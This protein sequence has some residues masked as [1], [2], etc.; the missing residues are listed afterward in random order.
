MTILYMDDWERLGAFPDYNTT[1]T[2]ALRLATVY[3]KMGIKNHMFHLCL[4]DKELVGVDPFA[5][6]LSLELK[7]RVVTEFKRNFWY[8]IREVIMIPPIGGVEPIKY[9][10]HRA[11]TALHWLYFNNTFNI[12]VIARQRGKTMAVICLMIWLLQSQNNI[13]IASI[14]K[15]DDLRSEIIR[16]FKDV[17]EAQPSYLHF[18]GAKHNDSRNLQEFSVNAFNNI[19]KMAVPSLSPKSAYKVGRGLTTPT[20]WS[21]ES[22]FSPNIG[23]SLGACIASGTYAREQAQL[24]DAPNGIILT[25]TA[26]LIDDRDAGY[27]YDLAMS[28]TPFTEKMYDLDNKEQC[29]RVIRANNR[30]AALRVYAVFNHRQLGVT[31]RQ[32]QEAIVM[33][34]QSKSDAE[35]DFLSIWNRGSSTHPLSVGILNDLNSQEREPDYVN[36]YH[37]TDYIVNWYIPQE[38]IDNELAE[39][40]ILALDPSEAIG[41]DSMGLV[42]LKADSG[43]VLMTSNQNLAGIPAYTKWL[44]LNFIKPYPNLIV[45]IENKSTGQ[46]VI[47]GIIELMVVDNINPFRRLFNTIAQNA[48]SDPNTWRE[49]RQY[50]LAHDN[51]HLKY[52]QRFGFKTSGTG[53]MARNILYGEV[54]YQS[55]KECAGIIYDKMIISQI[56]GLMEKNGKIVHRQGAHDDLVIA[57]LLAQ[58]FLR[59]GKNLQL[60]DIDST[61]VLRN[62]SRKLL[63]DKTTYEAAKELAL[64]EEYRSIIDLLKNNKNLNHFIKQRYV[65][66]LKGIESQIDIVDEPVTLAQLT[67]KKI[68]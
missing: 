14:S 29:H 13:K 5:D 19:F 50:R 4:Y 68:I 51:F 22:C 28:S 32:Q 45:I 34:N 21:E 62:N 39:A 49:V 9:K 10:F 55:V 24:V 53:A 54:F 67:D 66:A 23:I 47:D 42:L 52:K 11:N 46:S 15:D 43:R 59:L 64:R 36:I 20:V 35:R 44:Y 18:R 63:T 6:N 60:Y 56:N 1:N 2:R 38:Q 3:K 48:E 17:Y 16:I 31:D 58:W 26:G 30:E 57:Y 40:T 65:R 61:T 8:A 7:A 37:P 27:I 33:S 12:N 41:V 25:T